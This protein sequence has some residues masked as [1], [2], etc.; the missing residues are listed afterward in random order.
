MAGCGVIFTI[1]FAA[2]GLFGVIL[3][4]AGIEVILSG[5]R[6]PRTNSI[7]EPCGRPADT[8]GS[9]AP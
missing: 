5:V 8:S 3:A 6:I 1:P 9:T 2:V 4:G 7:I